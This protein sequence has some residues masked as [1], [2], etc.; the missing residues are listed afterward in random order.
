MKNKNNNVSSS[1]S[2][3]V[4]VAYPNMNNINEN[5]DL[6]SNDCINNNS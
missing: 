6:I 2:Y 1:F 5:V 3:S 4:D